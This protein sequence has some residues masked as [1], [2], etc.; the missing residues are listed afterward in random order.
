MMANEKLK[1]NSNLGE[2][3][4][5][6]GRVACVRFE[7]VLDAMAIITNKVTVNLPLN[8]GQND[9]PYIV[10]SKHL[11]EYITGLNP[12]TV[13]NFQNAGR[14]FALLNK[15]IENATNEIRNFVLGTNEKSRRKKKGSRK[16]GSKRGAS[17]RA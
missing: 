6:L 10:P 13:L 5:K 7:N 3:L 4:S 2:N 17:K 14:A 11:L 1:K 16:G 12:E 8:N 9:T 15:Q